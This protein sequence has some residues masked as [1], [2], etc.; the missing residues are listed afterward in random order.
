MHFHL[1]NGQV[2]TRFRCRHSFKLIDKFSRIS[3]SFWASQDFGIFDGSSLTLSHGFERTFDTSEMV[4]FCENIA[5]AI[6][7]SQLTSF[8]NLDVFLV[9]IN[10]QISWIRR[11]FCICVSQTMNWTQCWN[12]IFSFYFVPGHYNVFVDFSQG[13][14]TDAFKKKPKFLQKSQKY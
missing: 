7:S 5:A 2:L 13:L 9:A 11:L 14:P 3:F 8:I 12:I 10:R 1:R 4:W 6:L